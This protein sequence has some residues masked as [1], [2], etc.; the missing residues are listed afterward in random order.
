MNILVIG[1]NGQLGREI[2]RLSLFS[3]DNFIFTDITTVKDEE[4]IYL[5]S[6]DK[7]AV[8]VMSDSEGVDLIIN[9]AAYTNVEKAED[10]MYMADLLNHRVPEILAE[11]SLARNATL[12]HIS[13]DYVFDGVGRSLPYREVDTP[14]PCNVYGATK[15]AGEDAVIRLGCKYI[16]IRTSWLY[17]PYGKNFVSTILQ[18][19]RSGKDLRVVYDSVGTPTFA[20]DLAGVIMEIIRSAQLDKCGLYN[21]SNEGVAS[22]YDFAQAVREISGSSARIWPV[23]SDEYPTKAHRPAYSVLDKSLFKKTFGIEIPYWIDSLRK[24]MSEL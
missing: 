3:G 16:I 4:T 24:C 7:D 2:R 8:K 22:W 19:L 9:C 14:Q 21:Y 12:I 15:L 6:S 1:A 11:V 13:T 5:D 18:R 17:S 10:D 20:A 23:L